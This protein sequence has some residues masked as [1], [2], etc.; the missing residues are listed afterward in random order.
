MK[1]K[2]ISKREG[3]IAEKIE[4]EAFIVHKVSGQ[5]GGWIQ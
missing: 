1:F 5:G 2:P 3:L 4:N